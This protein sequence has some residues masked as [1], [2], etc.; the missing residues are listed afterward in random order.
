LRNVFFR[1]TDQ[2]KDVAEAD[3]SVTIRIERTGNIATESMMVTYTT[4]DFGSATE[5][6]DYTGVTNTVTFNTGEAFK[7]ITIDINESDGLSEG[8]ERFRVRLSNATG[9]YQSSRSKAISHH[10]LV[11]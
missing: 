11:F 10:R 3:G 6:A 9:G 1:V 5:N 2:N 7:D 8:F 4:V